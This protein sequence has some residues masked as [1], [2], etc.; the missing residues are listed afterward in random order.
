[1]SYHIPAGPILFSVVRRD[2]ARAEG[3]A[4]DA[5]DEAD[6]YRQA[7]VCALDLLRPEP[8]SGF[9]SRMDRAVSLLRKALD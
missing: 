5:R 7:I 6:T 2:I 1:M 9:R 8:P 3:D 4:T